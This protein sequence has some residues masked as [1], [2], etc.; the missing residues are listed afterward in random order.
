MRFLHTRSLT[1]DTRRSVSDANLNVIDSTK[2]SMAPSEP[3]LAESS[4]SSNKNVQ[5]VLAPGD[6]KLDIMKKN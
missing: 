2:N 3:Y 5:Q 6:L 1:A 4:I